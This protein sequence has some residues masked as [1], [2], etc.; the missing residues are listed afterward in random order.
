M[1][2]VFVGESWRQLQTSMGQ[3]HGEVPPP[4]YLCFDVM[5]QMCARAGLSHQND[6]YGRFVNQG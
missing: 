2:V 3:E 1:S 5:D 6:G 4:C